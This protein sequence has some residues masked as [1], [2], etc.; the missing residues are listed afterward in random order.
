MMKKLFKIG[1]IFVLSLGVSTHFGLKAASSSGDSFRKLKATRGKFAP[2]AVSG[3]RILKV[4]KGESL[5]AELAKTATRIGAGNF[6]KIQ[7]PP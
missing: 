1:I 3:E 4:R 7:I 6:F 5:P 2:R